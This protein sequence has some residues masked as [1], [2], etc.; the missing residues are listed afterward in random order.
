LLLFNRWRFFS[1]L[2]GGG[3]CC[4]NSPMR[5]VFHG[6]SPGISVKELGYD[7]RSAIHSTVIH[8]TKPLTLPPMQEGIRAGSIV[9]RW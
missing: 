3:Q 9:S 8:M 2:C 6:E 4:S 1:V 5:S 7:T